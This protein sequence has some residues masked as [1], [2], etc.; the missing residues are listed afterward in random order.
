M[1]TITAIWIVLLLNTI[2]W[3][4]TMINATNPELMLFSCIA[5]VMLCIFLSLEKKE[6]ESLKHL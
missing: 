2:L 4:V 6:N 3:I 5:E 1:K